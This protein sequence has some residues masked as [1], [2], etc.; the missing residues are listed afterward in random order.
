MH[1]E[2]INAGITNEAKAI[3]RQIGAVAFIECSALTLA[4]V[5]EVFTCGIAYCSHAGGATRHQK[6]SWLGRPLRRRSGQKCGQNF[7]TV[8]ADDKPPVLPGSSSAF[9]LS[10]C[11]YLF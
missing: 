11:Q 4:N 3:A 10:F 5:R 6:K 1:A 9:V 7:Q 8:L 2:N